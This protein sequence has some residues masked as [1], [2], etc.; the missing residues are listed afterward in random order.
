M[1]LSGNM[2]ID[3]RKKASSLNE[4]KKKFNSRSSFGKIKSFIS[5][6]NDKVSNS[7]LGLKNN[8]LSLNSTKNTQEENHFLCQSARN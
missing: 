7:A 6:K 3:N 1:M 2:Y 5:P 8:R 4:I